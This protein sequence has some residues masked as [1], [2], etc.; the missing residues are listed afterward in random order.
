MAVKFGVYWSSDEEGQKDLLGR[1]YCDKGVTDLTLPA[2]L[3]HVKADW[4]MTDFVEGWQRHTQSLATSVPIPSE[5]L[6]PNA[7]SDMILS[8]YLIQDP[9]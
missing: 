1:K 4:T 7:K 3:W 6:W 8:C 5:P 9:V 2:F